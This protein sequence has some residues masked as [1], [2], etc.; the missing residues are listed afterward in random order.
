VHSHH[1]HGWSDNLRSNV[2]TGVHAQIEAGQQFLGHR[3]GR[4]RRDLRGKPTPEASHV[5][6]QHHAAERWKPFCG[7]QRCRLELPD[8]RRVLLV[9]ASALA[10]LP[11]SS[12]ETLDSPDQM[13]LTDPRLPPIHTQR[14]RIRSWERPAAHPPDPGAGPV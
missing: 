6:D 5:R 1:L 13:D 9:V 10:Q 8:R 11:L 12:R 7:P 4:E 14:L 3:Q 2:T